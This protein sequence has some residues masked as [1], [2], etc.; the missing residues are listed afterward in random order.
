[1]TGGPIVWTFAALAA[2]GAAYYLGV[3]LACWK[4][5]GRRP[6]AVAEQPPLSILKPVRGLD[7][8]FEDNLRAH[9]EQSYPEL[10][11]L[12]GA[13]DAD[14]PALEA[15]RRIAAEYSE[16]RFEAVVC[17]P[18]ES[19]NRKV[20]V[21][22]ALAPRAR[23]RLLM[24]DDAD[25]RPS[26]TWLAETVAAMQ[27]SEAGLATCLY[28]A[29]PGRT[30]ASKID[31]LSISVGFAGQALLGAEIVGVPFALGAAMLFRR[32][33]L[34]RIGGFAAIRPY[35]A[36]DYQLGARIA[37][38]GRPIV[39][40]PSIVETVVGDVSWLETWRRHLRW[41]RTVRVSRRDGHL[42][43]IVT[44]GLVWSAAALVTAG[45][46]SLW[47]WPAYACLA[48]RIAAATAVAQT[49]GA[50]LGAA[51]LLLPVADFWAFGVWLASLSGRTVTWQ[52]RRLELDREGRI[53]AG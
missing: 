48:A 40:S 28:R 33:D 36:D 35:L 22:E 46:G 27:A 34:E 4:F 9:F 2:A 26:K 39:L 15:A 10:E 45:A 43:L 29:R 37:E 19:G 38:I 41:S 8:R 6:G 13:A 20:A 11:I 17:G 23:H 53:I 50:K 7:A 12:V 32:A 5:R 52:G 24:V 49:I 47:A 21:L 51:W 30:L 1:V 44:F 18:A 16:T 42:G 31:A 25:I 3:I 14:D